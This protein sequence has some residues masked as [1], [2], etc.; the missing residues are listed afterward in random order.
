MNY[1]IASVAYRLEPV[2]GSLGVVDDLKLLKILVFVVFILICFRRNCNFVLS[3]N[4]ENQ[5]AS[6]GV[7]SV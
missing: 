4:I 6:H 2:V 5:L 7:R 1:S 3:K